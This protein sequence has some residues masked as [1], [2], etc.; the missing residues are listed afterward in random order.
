LKRE[1]S[2]FKDPGYIAIG[3]LWLLLPFIN[4]GASYKIGLTDIN[5]IDDKQTWKKQAI[6][7]FAGF[8]F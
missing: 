4:F 2:I 7:I 1:R 8:T 5:A 6:Q 3:G